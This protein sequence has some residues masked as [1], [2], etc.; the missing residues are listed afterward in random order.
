MNTQSPLPVELSVIVPVVNEVAILPAFLTELHRQQRIK[1]ELIVVDGGSTDG[2]VKFLEQDDRV[3]LVHSDRGRGRQLNAGIM[4]AQGEWLLLLHADSRFPDPLAWRNGVDFLAARHTLR[5]AGHFALS[6]QTDG[7]GVQPGYDFFERKAR[8]S[9]PETIHGDQGFL[10]HRA[11]WQRVGPFR[12]DLPV[13]EDTD[14]AERLRA[15]GQWQLLPAE[16]QTSC[17]RFESEGLWQRQL[18]GALMMCFRCI[19]WCD[20]FAQAPDLYREQARA[21]QLRLSPFFDLIVRLLGD[22]SWREQWR[23]WRA[24]GDYIRGHGWQLFFAADCCRA[25]RQKRH[26]ADTPDVW[27]F[28]GEPVFTLL[29]DHPPGRLL[30]TFLLRAGFAVIRVGLR[31]RETGQFLSHRNG[32]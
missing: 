17:R 23:L 11:L 1:Y 22:L 32:G 20:F 21:R 19:G 14:F 29:T 5:V 12:E 3:R 26:V 10:L 9:R 16:I 28:W 4:A 15:I 6:F 8:S 31:K 30:C 24:A 18:L 2:S 25:R 13:M 7:N 27:R